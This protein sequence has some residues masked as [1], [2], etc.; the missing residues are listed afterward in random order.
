MLEVKNLTVRYGDLVI[1]DNIGFSL[2][3][4]RWLVVVGPN[5]SGK[6]TIVNAITGGAPYTGD[7][8]YEG[9]DVRRMKPAA[10][11]RKVGVL[12]QTNAAAYPFTVGEIVRLG[13]Y[14]HAPGIF[15]SSGAGDA[16]SVR[17]ALELTGM[18]PFENQSALTLS[19]GELQRAFLAQV[20][21]Q[22]PRLLIL[23]E[24]ANHLDL[25]YQKQ[26]FEQIGRWVKQPGRA[27]ISV[28]H[29]L[30]L[31]AA[32]GTDI[33]LLC[34]GRIVSAGD[35]ETVLSRENLQ[36]VYSMDVHAWMREMLIRW[37]G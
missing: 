3:E 34:K 5:G 7:I 29:D 23:D 10:L 21:A 30:S 9:R 18:L 31:A 13:R 4:N 28:V 19:G 24:P 17:K 27:V 36:A 8:L 22:D 35:A 6:S 15:K 16:G 1:V 26:T 14:S 25:A 33:M 12:S 37:G 20:L 11:A 32:Y 2:N